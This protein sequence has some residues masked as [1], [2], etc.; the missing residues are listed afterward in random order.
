VPA[1]AELVE[2]ILASMVDVAENTFFAFVEPC[3]GEAFQALVAG[4]PAGDGSAAAWSPWMVIE[5]AFHGAYGGV[6]SATM[7]RRL[8]SELVASFVGEPEDTLTE[9]QVQ[10]GAAEFGN[11]VCGAWLT[12]EAGQR[13]FDLEPPAVRTLGEPWRP[14]REG[15]SSPWQIHLSL[16][17]QPVAV[18][19]DLV[20]E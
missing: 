16:N 12:R 13:R 8:A 17:G 20:S 7:P 11:M 10:D 1:P 3:D 4:G 9:A 15:A 14:D 19:L 18:R 5:V 2:P 6:L